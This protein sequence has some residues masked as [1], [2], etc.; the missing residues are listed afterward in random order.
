MKVQI[1][2]STY[3]VSLISLAG[4]RLIKIDPYSGAVTLERVTGMAPQLLGGAQGSVSQT[5]FYMDPYVISIQTIGSGTNTSY[6]LINWTTA[7]TTT[8]FTARIMNNVSLPWGFVNWGGGVLGYSGIVAD[9]EANIMVWMVGV[10]PL[11]LGVY[12]GTWMMAVD[13][14]SGRTTLE[15]NLRRHTIQYCLFNCRS[16]NGCCPNGTRLLQRL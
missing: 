15:Q 6:R 11:P 14:T 12:H 13:M 3:S 1:A 9:F 4:N 8:N 2:E 5:G 16:R 10:A 7:G